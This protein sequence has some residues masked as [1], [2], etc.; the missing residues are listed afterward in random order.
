M[1]AKFE[2][3]GIEFL[4]PDNWK[5][6]ESE[7]PGGAASVTI[8]SPGG[9]FFSVSQID[10]AVAAAEVVDK[11]LETMRGEYPEV[12][13][14][15]LPPPVQEAFGDAAGADLNFF[16]LDLLVL[17]R[18]LAWPHGRG[19]LMVQMQGESREFG[20]QEPIFGAMLTSLRSS[21]V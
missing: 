3:W 13:V 5:Q 11:T 10:G 15:Q 2:R 18:I 4:Y 12:E 8:E 7:E 21:V 19:V 16:Y 6:F 9:A 14:G 20:E 1:P 17:G